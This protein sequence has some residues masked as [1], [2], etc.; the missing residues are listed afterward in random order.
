MPDQDP[1]PASNTKGKTKR[2]LVKVTDMDSGREL[3]SHQME[4]S[5][6]FGSSTTCCSS[7]CTPNDIDP[8][9]F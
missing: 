9:P 6:A 2:V 3:S 5:T 8:N 4:F 1:P 7:S